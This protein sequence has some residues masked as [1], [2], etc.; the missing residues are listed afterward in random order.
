V[1]SAADVLPAE[2]GRRELRRATALIVAICLTVLGAFA[3]GV[4]EIRIRILEQAEAGFRLDAHVAGSAVMADLTAAA[5]AAETA[6]RF[7]TISTGI[8][9]I[10]FSGF[11]GG[12]TGQYPWI[13]AL[14]WVPKVDHR[15]L[16]LFIDTARRVLPGYQIREPGGRGNLIPALARE[17]YFPV[18]MVE[19]LTLESKVVGLDLGV[20]AQMAKVLAAATATGEIRASEIL[21]ETRE[22]AKGEAIVL[23][24]PVY[25]DVPVKGLPPEL[26]RL[27]NVRGFALAIIDVQRVLDHAALQVPDIPLSIDLSPTAPR[28]AASPAPAGTFAL[29][30]QI[31]LGGRDWWLRVEAPRAPYL[32]STLV[33]SLAYGT[34]ALVIVIVLVAGASARALVKRSLV[35]RRL[36]LE[37]AA[38]AAFSEDILDTLREPVVI[39]D[40]QARIMRANRAWVD[41]QRSTGAGED[42]LGR[43]YL[44]LMAQPDR[45]VVRSDELTLCKAVEAVLLGQSKERDCDVRHRDPEGREE[46]F[47]IRIRAF[48]QGIGRDA[49]IAHTDITRLK[50][51]EQE[52]RQLAITD[53]LTQVANRRHFE[54]R[55]REEVDRSQRYGRPLVLLLLDIDHFKKVNDTY[56]HP[57]GDAVLRR[58]ADICQASIRTLDL[59][60]RFGGEEFAIL[61]P[62]TDVPGALQM[63]ERIREE[64]AASPVVYGEHV[65]KVTASLGLA[66][67][68]NGDRSVEQLVKAAD[69]MLYAAK[70]GG[71]NQV[72]CAA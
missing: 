68:D 60:A 70:Q 19:P 25:D 58:V 14:E 56:G 12:L 72:I 66:A 4:G 63:A 54:E 51:A 52:L 22:I 71:R 3:V 39:V 48:R 69:E 21:K 20:S 15:R 43:H 50:R 62:E 17:T 35:I 44:N 23:A 32:P 26:W 6:G 55:V 59:V 7:N 9:P 65:I 45:G 57:A 61:L 27:R 33:L 18:T 1:T 40:A 53:G 30:R 42:T 11:L 2:G 36:H 28:A 8:D 5:S 10:G 46:W 49:L 37:M 67:T 29:A 41:W 31:S 64:I 13:A 47:S 34:A 38:A 16:H 24:A